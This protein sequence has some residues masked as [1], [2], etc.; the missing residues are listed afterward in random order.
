MGDFVKYIFIAITVFVA[1][2]VVALVVTGSK[3]SQ[4]TANSSLSALTE[5]T[6]S[7]G[8]TT[9]AIYD[10]TTVSGTTVIDL[11]SK[12]CKK[13]D[14]VTINNTMMSGVATVAQLDVAEYTDFA[15]GASYAALKTGDNT[16]NS[17]H[18]V[19]D[20]A[21]VDNCK[22]VKRASFKCRLLYDENG[23]LKMMLIY[24]V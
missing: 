9:L 1:V 17:G 14:I 5:T 21:D 22:V 20:K 7:L 18:A 6:S 11:I 13:V 24:Q 2:G 23:E 10:E 8:D 15:T 19:Y 16:Y 3:Q 12:Y 4:E